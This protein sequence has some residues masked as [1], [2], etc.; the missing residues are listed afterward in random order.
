MKYIRRSDEGSYRGQKFKP[1][2]I[3]PMGEDL[4]NK[5][6]LNGK[7][8]PSTE[9]KYKEQQ[10][11]NKKADGSGDKTPPAGENPYA[12]KTL[13]ELKEIDYKSLN[14][15]PLAQFATACGLEIGEETKK[16]MYVLLETVDFEAKAD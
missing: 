11:A 12:G 15:D 4:A 5:V 16:Q 13:L 1:G 8:S 6:I 14:R 9:A 2:T 7:G 3:L 10:E